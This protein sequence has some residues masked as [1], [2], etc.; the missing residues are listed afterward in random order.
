MAV[1]A[2]NVGEREQG[3]PPATL[4]ELLA[5]RIAAEAVRIVEERIREMFETT[6]FDAD[7]VHGFMGSGRPRSSWVSPTP[8]SAR[9]LPTSP[10]MPSRR[11]AS[12]TFSASSWRGVGSGWSVSWSDSV[13]RWCSSLSF[14][15]H[16]GLRSA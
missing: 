8:A 14:R 5:M 7:E 9:S 13:T 16:K 15:A 11:R 2:L 3:Q 10:A 12:A 1:G 6:E 4:E